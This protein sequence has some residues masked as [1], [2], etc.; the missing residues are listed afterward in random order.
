MVVQTLRERCEVRARGRFVRG[1]DKAKA[2]RIT[3]QLGAGELRMQMLLLAMFCDAS[4]FGSDF[5]FFLYF[6]NIN[7][8][9]HLNTGGRLLVALTCIEIKYRAGLCFIT[10]QMQYP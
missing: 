4:K 7:P 1:A 2:V 9:S 8:K 10:Q 3:K 5:L 6:S